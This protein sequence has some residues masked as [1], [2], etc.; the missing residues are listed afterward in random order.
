MQGVRRRLDG[1]L[2]VRLDSW[3]K[4]GCTRFFS[5]PS[6]GC[7][8]QK[9]TSF[10][11][12]EIIFRE[13]GNYGGI[14]WSSM[15]VSSKNGEC[16]AKAKL[17]RRC[18]VS[19]E[20]FAV[21]YNTR[22]N[23]RGKMGQNLELEWWDVVIALLKMHS[24]SQYYMIGPQWSLNPLLYLSI[25]WTPIPIVF[26]FFLKSTSPFNFRIQNF[27]VSVR[28]VCMCLCSPKFR[29]I[30]IIFPSLFYWSK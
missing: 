26:F 19:R 15:R 12:R 20:G 25:K 10:G 21:L 5:R 13:N 7:Q 14:I 23:E 17:I 8:V 28:V 16:R 30:Q 2:A 3:R 29:A 9:K 1:K 24:T 4:R 18:A 6:Y 22:S 27:Y 11:R